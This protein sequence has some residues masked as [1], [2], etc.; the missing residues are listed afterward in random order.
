MKIIVA[1]PIGK[2]RDGLFYDL[3]PSRWS[4]ASEFH[5][6]TYYPFDLAYLSSMLKRDTQQQIKMIDGNYQNYTIAKY[7]EVLIAEQPDVIIM[8][9]DS[10]TYTEDMLMLQQVKAQHPCKIIM[11]GPYPTAVPM[12]AIADGADFVAIGEFQEAI[13]ELINSD[14]NPET[15]GI[16]PNGRH[17]L[18]E[19]NDMPLPEDDDI[20]RRDYC[21]MYA[22]EF[23]EIEVFPTRGCPVNC[24]YCVVRNV[25]HG[26]GNFRTR[27]VSSVIAEIRG[28][29]DKYPELEGIFFNEESH[30]ANKRYVI[31]LCDALIEAGLSRELVF[32]CMCN[33]YSLDAELIKRMREANYY[34]VRF[35]IETLDLENKEQIFKGR[36][37]Q[38]TQ[39]LM[40][41]LNACKEHGMRVYVTLSVGTVGS[42]AEKDRATLKSVRLLFESGLLHEFQVSINTPM[43]GT[44]FYEIAKEKGYLVT[45]DISAQNGIAGSVVSFPDYSKAQID[46]VFGEFVLLR[47]E[48]VN[49]NMKS[50]LKYSMYDRDWVAKVL[51][52]TQLSKAYA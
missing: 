16:W 39:R 3:F 45:E 52:M 7:T 20:S 51:E 50:G 36:W 40:D 48:I 44:P 11:C 14:F 23:R 35:G 21:R 47:D 29:K 30:T 2:S 32:N 31:E 9:A 19:V 4:A 27:E 6:N 49:A 15:M 46:E 37:K 5:S 42:T 22:C 25:Y 17:E 13:V 28:L 33:Y 43:P 18:M 12:K 34:K 8:E 38:D 10:L 24:N 1:T 26:K 41:V